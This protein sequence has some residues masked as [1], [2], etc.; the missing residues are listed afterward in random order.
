[1]RALANE[2]Q[3]LPASAAKDYAFGL[4]AIEDSDVPVAKQLLGRAAE[5]AARSG[6]RDL[7][8]RADLALAELQL[9]LNEADDAISTTAD[10]TDI[11]DDELV[12]DL[13]SHRAMALWQRGDLAAALHLLADAPSSLPTTS[14]QPDMLAVR[15]MVRTLTGELDRALADLDA[16]LSSP[17]L[18]R[19]SSN[20]SRALIFRANTRYYVGDW[21]G[22]AVDASAAR[23]VADGQVQ[24]W[25]APMANAVSSH[26]PANR[27]Q[28]ELAADRLERAREV[29]RAV[30]ST[31]VLGAVIAG[32]VMLATTFE[33]W[34]TVQRTL[35]PLRNE[36]VMARLGPTRMFRWVMTS[37]VVACLRL[38]DHVRA[39][40]A[41]VEY[42]ATLA[43]WPGGPIPA[44]LEWLKG[45]LAEARDDPDAAHRHYLAELADPVLVST[46]FL[47]AQ[48]LHTAGHLNR[49][50]GHRRDAIEK[51]SLAQRI[52]LG[53]RAA[54]YAERCSAELAACGLPA[55]ASENGASGSDR[56]TLT[57]REEDVV[58]L[59]AR[60]YT[61]R[62][63]AAEL[64]VTA[65][66]VEYHLGNVF[67]K[68]G[69]RSRRELRR[70]RAG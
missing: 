14:W 44:R 67:A 45:Q 11:S 27:G 33:D 49:V 16:A 56:L 41:V 17:G 29:L 23:A 6:H 52:F 7:Q 50:T 66:T 37:W 30:H 60:G 46:P 21:D 42:E 40:D 70:A 15:G 62:E 25:T 20:F 51:V 55:K 26:V 59:V 58:A 4:L 5:Q 13:R 22:A 48:V 38:G 24:A 65:K 8:A 68:L 32:E 36:M 57:E 54:P 19:R 63:I 31:P 64:F 39:A 35:T 10:A 43:R 61:N 47:H 12:H 53:L 69:L 2:A 3:T 18:W 1:M 9:S 28:R 34:D